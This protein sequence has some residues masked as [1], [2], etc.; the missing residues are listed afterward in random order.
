M[1]IVRCV[2]TGGDPGF[3]ATDQSPTAV[4]YAVLSILLGRQVLADCEGG[5]PTSAEVDAV[6]SPPPLTAAQ[7]QANADSALN[8]VDAP[9]NLLK[10]IK[11]KVVSDLAFRLGVTPGA[12]TLAQLQAERTRIA[13]IYSAL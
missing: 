10:L 12:L 5:L 9:I 2:Y 11:A 13:N 8:G 1:S 6:L 3:P 7:L 4:R